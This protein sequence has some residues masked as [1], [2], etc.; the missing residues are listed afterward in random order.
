MSPLFFIFHV[1]ESQ[2]A[3]L[4]LCQDVRRLSPSLSALSPWVK[5]S[6]KTG[7]VTVSGWDRCLLDERRP[8]TR[9][10][11][12]AW[13]C[14]PQGCVEGRGKER[15]YTGNQPATWGPV[16]PKHKTWTSRN[17]GW[18]PP[19]SQTCSGGSGTVRSWS[20]PHMCKGRW[21]STSLPERKKRE[22]DM[23][24]THFH[25]LWCIIS[26]HSHYPRPYCPSVVIQGSALYVKHILTSHKEE[27]SS[28]ILHQIMLLTAAQYAYDPAE[29]DDGYGHAY[30]TGSHPL[31]VCKTEVTVFVRGPVPSFSTLIHQDY[32]GKKEGNSRSACHSSCL[33][34]FVRL[35]GRFLGSADE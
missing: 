9:S 17:H 14:A 23:T 22:S 35:I 31:E 15:V 7:L 16:H 21:C 32:Q 12:P 8:V 4:S 1:S 28:D 11:S 19:V 29:Q 3:V 25:L 26:P 13:A 24:A 34:V 33:I 5:L 27:K 18:C 2:C 10:R 20:Q 6:L 30:E